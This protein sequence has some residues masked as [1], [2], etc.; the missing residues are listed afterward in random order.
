[1]DR[2]KV[3]GA[4]LAGSEAA[5]Y[6]A[7]HGVKVE[8][9]DIK[10]RK[11]TPAHSSQK[12]GELVCSNSLKGADAYSNA[13]GLLKEE[14][15]RIGSLTMRAAERARI[16]AGGALAVDRD[17]FAGYITEELRAQENIEIVCGEA[18]D[19]PEAPCIIATGPLTCD[20][21]AERIKTRLGGALHFY[22]ASAPIVTR[23]SVDISRAFFGD[24]YGKG[25]DDYL[26]CPMNRE[27]YEKFVSELVNAERAT[28]H[29]FE[30]REI[31]EGC[32]PLEIMA[33]RGADTLRFGPFKP[34]GLRDGEGNR[35]YAVLQLR[36]E[37]AEGTTYNL[38]GCQTNLKF[39]EQR[40]VFSL[41]PAL[42]EAEFTRYGVMHRNTYL[43][44]PAVLNADF[45]LKTSPLVF[46]A[47]Q[48]TGVEGYV[49]SAASGLLA[50]VHM[51]AKLAGKSVI[52]PDNTTVSGA[53]SAH[54][55]GATDNFQPMNANFG[56]LKPLDKCVRDKKQ[57]YAA[58][59]VRALE[60]IDKFVKEI[61]E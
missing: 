18:E 51:L 40:R 27:E 16:P 41:V 11:F 49:E 50:A 44:S 56:I 42:K 6:L 4:G 58:L 47:G 54:I 15:R 3:I 25:G 33:A 36:K 8:L 17:E 46:F 37:N 34:V 30:K 28:L 57:R 55:A 26:N 39:G 19:I 38:V 22:D 13:C 14:M 24:R 9:Y 5:Y 20:A 35:F 31:F 2:V 52:I 61:R 60:S 12:F 23:E 32:M 43:N 48:M 21:L 1:M 45:S 59:A 7:T 29:G 53:L 10:P